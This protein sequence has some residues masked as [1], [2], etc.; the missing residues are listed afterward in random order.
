MAYTAVG[1]GYRGLGFWSDR[2]LADSHSGRDRLL[3]LA[4]INQELQMLEPILLGD[5]SKDPEWIDTSRPEVKAAVLRSDRGILVL[6][7]WLGG[8]GQFVPGQGAVPELTVV[9]PQVPANCQA[10][11][12]SPGR[13]RSYKCERVLGGTK[14]KL[15]DFN[16]TAAIVFTADLGPTGLVVRF[17][18]Q[19]RRLRKLAAQY[20]HDLAEEELAKA[21]R[22]QAELDRLGHGIPDGEALAARARQWL[23]RCQVARRDGQYA[24]AYT[25]A[26]VALQA[27][28]LLMRAHWDQAV[29]G[30]D[31]PMSSPYTV[32]FYTLPRHWQL[33]E[34]LRRLR[35]GDNV[36]PDGDF[37][38]PPDRVP[39]H[40]LVEEVPSLDEVQASARRVADVKFQGQQSLRLRVEGRPGRPTP[41]ALERTFMALH[42]PV[43]HL[44]P[45]TVVKI[46]ACVNLPG[47]IAS[48][49]DGVLFYD[50]IGGEPLA[51]RLTEG[52]KGW[53][54]YSF[55]RRVPSS[56]EV[57]VTMALTGLGTVY[58]DEVKIRP[59]VAGEGSPPAAN[60]E[61][62]AGR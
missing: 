16:L 58:F 33:V 8:N 6:P 19:Q 41:A 31:V 62:V 13:L 21:L 3:E 57:N 14:I 34:E 2:F 29:R 9:V 46:S 30:E 42:S 10:W 54:Q 1:C 45:G 37:E 50:S 53:K 22:V 12:V 5:K 38:A 56:G 55:Y 49:T 51:L 23:D 4:L 7:I 27:V 39:P 18:E 11:E 52:T 28:R 36:L 43:V 25:A 61:G 44:P 48:S 20:S 26:Q 32:S 24:E 47:P 35:A 60:R 15:H 40:W 17:Q 59:M